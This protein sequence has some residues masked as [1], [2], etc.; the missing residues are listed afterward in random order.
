MDRSH[1]APQYAGED[2]IARCH[3]AQGCCKFLLFPPVE[4][5]RRE[6]RESLQRDMGF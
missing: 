3:I 5:E 2:C 6:Q 1:L 4:R